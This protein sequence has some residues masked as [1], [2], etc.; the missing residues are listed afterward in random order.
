MSGANNI[1]PPGDAML[2]LVNAH[3]R[4]F[5]RKAFGINPDGT[6]ISDIEDFNDAP[7]KTYR[8]V[9]TVEQYKEIVRILTYW[10]DD[11]FLA[12]A[13]EGD[14]AV[15][16]IRR[17]RKAN[18]SVGYNYSVHFKLLHTENSD[19]TPKTVLVHKKTNGI[20]LHMLDVFDVILSAHN[21]QGHL[22]SERTLAAL[23]PQYY[24]VTYDLVKLFVEDCAVCHQ[25]NSGIEKKK[26]A[27]KPIISSEFRDRFQVD[28]IDMRT[29]RRRDVY[30]K[31]M[32]WIMTVKDH[33]TGLIYLVALPRKMA[34]YVAAELEKYF[35]FVGYPAI[36]HTGT[37]TF[38]LQNSIT[39]EPIGHYVTEMYSFI[40]SYQT[41][42][43][44]L[45]THLWFSCLRQTTQ[46]ASLSQGVHALHATKAQSREATRRFSVF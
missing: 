16:E 26:G 23:K 31:M 22:K 11:A 3:R 25:K 35:G 46:T 28:L 17:F 13:D 41:M 36:F 33:S 21:Q 42:A 20:V 12:T 7:T 9:K 40:S 15:S 18:E 2:Y 14:P 24:S 37:F 34:K 19:G 27:R 44:S 8:L 39:L 5:L 6:P 10:G 43:R 32:R 30:G 38:V 4:L 1:P 29:I 45:L